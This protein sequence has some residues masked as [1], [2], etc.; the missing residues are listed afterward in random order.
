MATKYTDLPKSWSNKGEVEQLRSDAA[1]SASRALA[2]AVAD[3][4]SNFTI[5]SAFRTKQDQIDLFK[6]NYKNTGGKRKTKSTDRWYAGTVWSRRPGS[7]AVA[8]PDLYGTGTGANHTLGIAMDIGPDPIRHWFQT[9]GAKYGWSWAEGKRNGESWHFVYVQANDQMKSWGFLDHAAVQKAVGAEV[10]G[11]IGTGTVAK[12]KDFQ[13]KHNLGVDGKVGPKT[14]AALLGKVVEEVV[15]DATSAVLIPG[16]LP[17]I[18]TTWTATN[19]NKER[20]GHEIKHITIH[21]WGTPSGQTFDGIASYL[22]DNSRDVSAHYVVGPGRVASLASEDWT[23]WGN[24]D[25]TANREGIVIECD[26]NHVLQTLPTL[27][28]LIQYIRKRRGDLPL[29]PHNHWTSTECPG[30]YEAYL[31]AIDEAARTGMA[32][33]A[34]AQQEPSPVSLPTPSS[35]K[36]PTGKDLLMAIIDAPD[37]PLLRTD[38]HKCYYGDPDGPVESVSGK[39]E[40]SLNPGEIGKK[41]GKTYSKG[42]LTLQRQLNARGYSVD[43][44]GRWGNQMA[45]AIDNLQRIAGL[46]RDKKVGPGTWYA[47]WILP[48]K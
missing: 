34:P 6:A 23:C 3:T 11:K 10:D 16:P 32:P 33:V 29:Y 12:I 4:G 28:A 15:E 48:V 40:N 39:S 14:K 19:V 1:A 22:A 25:R 45:N 38:D 9:E 44:D 42:L 43:E 2:A 20:F 26:P 31:D 41:G 30:D 35:D 37:F 36:L 18:E 17:T 46:T 24:G 5:T 27:V 21:W 7:V 13:R 47:A 8:S